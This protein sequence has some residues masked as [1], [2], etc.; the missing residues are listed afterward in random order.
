MKIKI[1]KVVPVE[2]KVRPK[3]DEVYDVVDVKLPTRGRGN[4]RTLY[5]IVVNHELVGVFDNECEVLE[6]GK[7]K[8]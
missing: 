8:I 4:N 5:Y 7:D 1:T 2:E 3:I 6:D